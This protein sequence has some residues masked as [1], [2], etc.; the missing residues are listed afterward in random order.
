[1]R[2]PVEDAAAVLGMTTG[3]VSN[4]LSRGTLR[5]V[6]ERGTVYVLSPADTSSRDAAQDT[7]DIPRMSSALMS[8]MRDL[9]ALLERKLERTDAILLNIAEAM[10]DISLPTQE[11]EPS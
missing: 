1:L 3:A 10:K 11:E 6:E 4:R 2:Y 7:G 5:S 9:I 8:E